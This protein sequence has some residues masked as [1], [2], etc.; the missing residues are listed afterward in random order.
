MHIDRQPTTATPPSRGRWGPMRK[1]GLVVPLVV[2]LGAATAHAASR[3]V[4]RGAGFGHGIGM[5]QYGA[6]GLAL[7]G[8]GYRAILSR[9]YQNTSLAELDRTPDVRVLL[10]AGRRSVKVAGAVSVGGRRRLNPALTYRVVRRGAGL[11]IRQGGR[12][13]LTS[14]PPMRIAAPAGGSLVLEG[15]S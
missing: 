9:Y 8:V 15:V 4:I 2:L 7:Q 1:L 10:Q 11:V 3:L 6:F 14:A 13:L 5:S 12:A